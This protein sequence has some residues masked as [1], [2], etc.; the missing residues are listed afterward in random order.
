MFLFFSHVHVCSLF[1]ILAPPPF[2]PLPH[3]FRWA[4][5]WVSIV[6][7]LCL[8]SSSFIFLSPFTLFSDSICLVFFFSHLSLC[9][10]NGPF[11]SFR[12]W[13]PPPIVVES[14]SGAEEE[15][16]EVERLAER[17]TGFLNM[18]K[19]SRR[20]K[21]NSS[22]LLVHK[23]RKKTKYTRKLLI[24]RWDKTTI[25]CNKTTTH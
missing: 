13:S 14:E 21:Q 5:A 9:V 6:F 15:K 10:A 24:F 18:N 4:I 12:A 23:W 17:P 19:I 20:E 1:F 8:P 11:R 22:Y 2:R 7:V 25:S 3:R 16:H